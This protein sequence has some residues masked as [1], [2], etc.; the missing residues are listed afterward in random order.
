METFSDEITLIR[1]DVLDFA[2]SGNVL[3]YATKNNRI[4]K[5]D[6]DGNDIQYV[7]DGSCPI[8]IGDYL[9]Y[10]NKNGKI[11]FTRI[12]CIPSPLCAILPL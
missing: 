1:N 10:H 7:A 2:V 4:Y 11:V 8:I 12:D 3:Y 6:L 5:A 9:F